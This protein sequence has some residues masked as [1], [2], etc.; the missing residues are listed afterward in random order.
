[1]LPK[2]VW[3]MT[4]TKTKIST[5]STK[6]L[7]RQ[8]IAPLPVR[9]SKETP[10]QSNNKEVPLRW[11]DNKGAHPKWGSSRGTTRRF[12]NSMIREKGANLSRIKTLAITFACRWSSSQLVTLFKE[13]QKS[14]LSLKFLS[15]RSDVKR[16]WIFSFSEII[17]RSQ[18]MRLF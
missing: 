12:K 10:R 18:S 1:M 4:N 8:I 9:K 6:T 5:W 15:L 13:T 7:S 3:T 14:R 17:T 2:S 16:K 11:W